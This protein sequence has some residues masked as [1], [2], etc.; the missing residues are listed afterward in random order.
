[1]DRHAFRKKQK[2]T[3]TKNK[4][5]DAMRKHAK[6]KFEMTITTLTSMLQTANVIN[7]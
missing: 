4:K 3:K 2:K 7:K 1:M 5:H 6:L